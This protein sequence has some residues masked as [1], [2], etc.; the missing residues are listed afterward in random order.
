MDRFNV[1]G[2]PKVRYCRGCGVGTPNEYCKSCLPKTD[3]MDLESVTETINPL[4]EIQYI[5]VFFDEAY[6][7]ADLYSTWQNYLDEIK[8]TGMDRVYHTMR[9]QDYLL[10]D[11]W[12]TLRR[13]KREQAGHCCQLCNTNDPLHIHHRTYKRRGYEELDDLIVLCADCHSLFHTH[14]RLDEFINPELYED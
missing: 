4:N 7:V 13:I 6:Q 5:S 11:H 12:A 10:T 1:F 3:W 8:R 2:A 9:Y 14:R